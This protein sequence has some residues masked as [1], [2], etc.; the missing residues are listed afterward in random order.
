MSSPKASNDRRNPWTHVLVACCAAFILTVFLMVAAAFNRQA[1]G[2]TRFF[3]KHGLLV[4]GIEV[5]ATLFVAVIVMAVERR[6]TRRQIE[7]RERMLLA[8]QEELSESEEL[9]PR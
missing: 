6:E 5:G 3:D 1:A 9:E 8:E 2:L 7:E 4:L